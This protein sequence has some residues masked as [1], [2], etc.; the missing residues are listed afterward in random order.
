[1]R[2]LD[3]TLQSVLATF[4]F[5]PYFKLKVYRNG[6]LLTTLDVL[7]YKLTGTHLSV[8]TRG[9]ISIS[10]A[11]DW[12]KVV[13]ER[14]IVSN[15]TAYVLDSSK[16]TP[17]SGSVE[18]LTSKSLYVS[19]TIEAELVSPK[20]VSFDGSTSYQTV[21]TSFCTAIG[22]T[23]VFKNPGAA[24]WASQFMPN[25]TT[26]TLADARSFL[27]LLQEKHLIFASDN[28]GEAIL[29]FC[30]VD[31]PAGNYD[32]SIDPILYNLGTGYY[33][34][35]RYMATD[36]NNV[37][38]YAGTVGDRLFN[39]GYK[40][41]ADPF[42]SV[43]SQ[44]Q[45][46]DFTLPINLQYQDGDKFGIDG[47]NYT[48]YPAQVIETFDPKASP[49][50]QVKVKQLQYFGDTEGGSLSSDL[51]IKTPYMPVNTSMFNHILGPATNNIQSCFDV[52]DD[53]THAGAPASQVVANTTALTQTEGFLRWDSTR[54]LLVLW[55]AQRERGITPIG[56]LPYAFPIGF[57]A[58]NSAYSALSLA[59]NGGSIAIPFILTAPMLLESVSIYELST[60][61]ARTFGWDLYEQY[62]NNGNAGE[63]ALTRV[64]ASNGSLTFTPTVA[65]VRTLAALAVTFLPAGIYWLVL[66]NRHASSTLAL[67]VATTASPFVSNMAQTKTTT[68]P[69]GAT[70]D[71]VAATWT[72]VT[73]NNPAVRLNG[74][75]FGQTAAF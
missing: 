9:L 52:L 65:S 74:R 72:K 26:V 5:V 37:V 63:N 30:A 67:A 41:D 70:L 15:G 35:R 42:P 14:G 69:N 6:A 45:L 56:W 75:V 53:H 29:F 64:V 11:P 71:F 48:M 8:T 59:A 18:R 32:A 7:K 13:L 50:W 40:Y 38:T 17:I 55:D 20:A 16:F 57:A 24:Y 27:P 28:G 61:T 68:N 34:R 51:S 60:A 12:I 54:K 3:A 62:L 4:H 73:S 47:N 43:Y 22:K 33:A 2:T 25:G 31:I 21:I 1:M 39:L 23:P 19:T 10:T 66:Q 36:E 58:N 46:L 49:G 44:A